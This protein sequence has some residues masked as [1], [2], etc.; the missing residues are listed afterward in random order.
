MALI[1]HE[2]PSRKYGSEMRRERDDDK[3]TFCEGECHSWYHAR[4][5]DI[6]NDEYDS[7]TESEGKW[8]C[9]ECKTC[10]LP[11]FNSVG[12]VDV[13]HLNFQQNLPTPKQTVGTVLAT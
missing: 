10:D 5:V 6:S 2:Y 1:D 4:C 7:L 8:E 11:I 3:A 9:S 12:A 13:F